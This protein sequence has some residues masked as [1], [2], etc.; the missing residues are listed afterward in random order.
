MVKCRGY[1]D[2]KVPEGRAFMKSTG[3]HRLWFFILIAAVAAFV[4]GCQR[5]QTAQGPNIILITIDTL[6]ADRLGAYGNAAGLTPAIDELARD[7][8]VF[9]RATT[10]MGTTWPAHT[11][12]LTGLYPRRHGV[13]KNGHALSENTT[14]IA[15]LLSRA[16]YAT[17]SFVSYRGMHYNCGLDRGFDAASDRDSGPLEAPSIRDGRAVTDLAVDWVESLAGD[18]R[19]AFLWMHLFEPHTPYEPNRY[20]ERLLDGRALP[21]VYADGLTAEELNGI[22][23]AVLQRP[24]EL[25]VMHALY[26]AEVQLADQYVGELIDTLARAGRL[27]NSVVIV[28]SDHGQ[29]LGDERVLAHGPVLTEAV[30]HVPMI[31]RDFRNGSTSRIAD[32]VSVVDLAPTLMQLALG[33]PMPEVDGRSL[34]DYLNGSPSGDA[35][36][37]TF[38]EVALRENLVGRDWYDPDALAVYA[39]GLKFIFEHDEFRVFDPTSIPSAAAEIVG[40]PQS[41]ALAAYLGSVAE[42]YLAG[43]VESRDAELSDADIEALRSLGYLQ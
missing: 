4:A 3:L 32:N 21:A 35:E 20:T 22:G 18:D 41:E 8:V 43:E 38:A 1:L 27:D 5:A 7:G 19:P 23:L 37:D 25:A 15:E 11:S 13:R 9:E 39:D 17:G 28:T 12:M 42:S 24:E 14:T 34:T 29:G 26:D 2:S 16:G 33:L 31:V 36:R 30:L 40:D 10:V 6:R